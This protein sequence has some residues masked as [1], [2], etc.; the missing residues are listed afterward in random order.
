[1]YKES[2]SKRIYMNPWPYKKK[3]VYVNGKYMTVVA[4]L[5]LFLI[6]QGV[7]YKS[8][9]RVKTVFKLKNEVYF[10]NK[11]IVRYKGTDRCNRSV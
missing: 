5:Q 6:L 4:N 8:E 3:K 11:N 7:S 10:N 2:V 1:M 9:Y